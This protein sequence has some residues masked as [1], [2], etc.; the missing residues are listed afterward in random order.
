MPAVGAS[1]IGGHS[2]R[3]TVFQQGGYEWRAAIVGYGNQGKVYLEDG[4]WGEGKVNR[5]RVESPKLRVKGADQLRVGMAWEVLQGL[6]QDW[7]MTY[8]ADFGL[9]D[10]FSP[11]FPRMHFL[12]REVRQ[13]PEVLQAPEPGTA[14]LS[15][16]AVIAAIVLM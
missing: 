16:D 15:P 2:L 13:A 1:S 7:E 3:D 11:S 10:V 4:F 9:T 5:I 8:L 12:I 14:L 6:G